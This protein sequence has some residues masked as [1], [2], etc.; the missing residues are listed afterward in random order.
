[1]NRNRGG[2]NFGNQRSGLGYGNSGMGPNYGRDQSSLMDVKTG[3]PKSGGSDYIVTRYGGNDFA[4]PIESDSGGYNT[5]QKTPEQINFGKI[6]E[7]G[8][9]F[10]SNQGLDTWTVAIVFRKISY[11]I[12]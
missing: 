5:N 8:E 9:S 11:I 3:M 1:M 2:S 10:W 12:L 4:M 7:I 6:L